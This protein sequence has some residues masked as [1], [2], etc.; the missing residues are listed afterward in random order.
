VIVE[1]SDRVITQII[2]AI[3]AAGDERLRHGNIPITE[4][5]LNAAWTAGADIG[6]PGARVAYQSALTFTEEEWSTTGRWPRG[7]S[8]HRRGQG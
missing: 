7:R 5:G 4:F 3:A 1:T 8:R 2:E 6:F